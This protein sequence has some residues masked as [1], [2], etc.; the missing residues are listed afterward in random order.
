MPTIKPIDKGLVVD[1]AKRTRAVVTCENHQIVKGLGS[2]VSE[3]L[4][5]QYP[6]LLRRVGVNEEFGE[7][8]T[9]EYLQQRYR[10]TADEIVTKAKE[11]NN[12]KREYPS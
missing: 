10:L 4:S 12:L 5:E 11:I 2:A 6:T 1:Y 7:V 3:V 9:L 8:G